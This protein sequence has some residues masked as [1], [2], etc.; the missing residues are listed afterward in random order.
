MTE[1]SDREWKKKLQKWRNYANKQGYYN[2]ADDFAQWMAEQELKGIRKTRFKFHLI[3]FLRKDRI[4]L[5]RFPGVSFDFETPEVAVFAEENFL[6]GLPPS[7]RIKA[8]AIMILVFK[9]G[10][11]QEEVAEVFGVSNSRISQILEKLY[12]VVRKQGQE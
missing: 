10:L 9:W 8:K 11:S 3:D 1:E 12:K 5:K 7:A 4:N 6:E 2:R